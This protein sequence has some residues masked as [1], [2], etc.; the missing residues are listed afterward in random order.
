MRDWRS[1]R[2]SP[3]DS[4]LKA[5]E[6]INRF[7]L[8]IALVV[9][10][11]ERL[12]GTVVDGDIRR[13]VL[14]G[15]TL[16][17]PVERAM[18]VNPVTAEI[19]Q[20]SEVYLNLMLAREIQQL[21]LVTEGNKVVG[22]VLLRD[23][24]SELASGLKAVIMA[25]GLGTRLRPLTNAVPKPMLPVGDRP[26][27][28]HVLERLREGGIHEV[29]ITTHYK[30]EM[31][32]EHFGEGSALG[33]NIQYVNE[34]QRFGTIGGLR[35]IREALREPFLVINCDVLT[36]LDFGAMRVF[37][38]QHAAEMTVAVRKHV[39]TVPYGVVSVKEES[40]ISLEEKPL[41][42]L[43]INAGVYLLNPEVVGFIPDSGPFD[44]TDLIAKLIREKRRV[45]AFPILEYWMDVGQPTDYEQANADVRSGR[46]GDS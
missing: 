26:L 5:M 11:R 28:A 21:P 29:V 23:L 18:K 10:D 44:A 12:I 15:D 41:I 25:G 45:A 8:G 7:M 34:E 20:A 35:L 27:M 30:S 24:H 14:R 42:Q 2:L 37:H 33:L 32:R 31:I 4:L 39:L 40:V 36:S 22:L 46:I 19:D 13:A 38:S 17:S 9:D 16:Q 6:V 1:V 43:F 3:Q